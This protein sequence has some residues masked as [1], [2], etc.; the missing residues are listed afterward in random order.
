MAGV[1]SSPLGRML[2]AAAPQAALH[3]HR[4]PPPPPP[5]QP[6]HLSLTPHPAV[7][8]TPPPT[9]PPTHLARPVL[10]HRVPP[11]ARPVLG[12]APDGRQVGGVH[13]HNVVKLRQVGGLERPG[14][15][16]E[17]HAAPAGRRPHARVCSI[18]LM[19]AEPPRHVP[20]GAAA[21]GAARVDREL[22]TGRE[23]QLWCAASAAACVQPC[24]PSAEQLKCSRRGP[25]GLPGITYA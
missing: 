6:A 20:V 18:S 12:C 2:I 22:Q 7:P 21:A 11:A 4:P 9:H 8:H 3:V 24:R 16:G 23:G 25:A 15:R 17:L 14:A 5:A 1:E 13:A 10:R 19:V